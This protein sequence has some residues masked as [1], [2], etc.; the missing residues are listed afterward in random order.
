[1][2]PDIYEIMSSARDAMTVRRAFGEP[3]ERDGVTLVPVA[4]IGGGFGAGT[5]RADSSPDGTAAHREGDGGGWGMGAVPVGAYSIR[6]GR[7]RFHPAVNVN[8][9]ILAATTLAATWLTTRALTTRALTTRAL[10]GR[11][12]GR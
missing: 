8:L 3:I 6:D 4:L 5:G 10:T 9:V 11:R 12:R 7:V 2:A 1:M